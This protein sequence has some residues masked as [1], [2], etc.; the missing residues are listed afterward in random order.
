M[1]SKEEKRIQNYCKDDHS[2]KVV[3][4]SFVF[5]VFLCGLVGLLKRDVSSVLINQNQ[6]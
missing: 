2:N 3:V 6:V 5:L 1:Q 4:A